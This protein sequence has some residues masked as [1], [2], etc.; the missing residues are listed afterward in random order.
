MFVPAAKAAEELI[1]E[2]RGARTKMAIVLDDFGGTAG[3]VTLEDLIEEIVG[4]IQDEFDLEGPEIVQ[5]E[6]GKYAVAGS[7]LVEDL[8]QALGVEI[9][10]RDEDTIAGVVLSELGRRP[11]PGDRVSLGPLELFV[12]D[13]RRNRIHSLEARRLDEATDSEALN[14]RS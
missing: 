13:V 7:T 8:E 12:T 6:A 14:S 9:S 3:L 11:K 2:M 4:E 5:L 1:G 10:D